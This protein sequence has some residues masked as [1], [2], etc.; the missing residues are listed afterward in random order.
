MKDQN[1]YMSLLK[2]KTIYFLFSLE[3]KNKPRTIIIKEITWAPDK[4]RMYFGLTLINSMKNLEIPTRIR[5]LAIK[6]PE[7][8]SFF[9]F[10]LRYKKIIKYAAISNNWVG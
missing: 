3:Y 5:Y 1:Y 8:D 7:A 10:N 2:Q 9:L 6:L 4:P